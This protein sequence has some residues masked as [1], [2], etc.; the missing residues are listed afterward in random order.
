MLGAFAVLMVLFVALLLIQPNGSDP[1]ELDTDKGQS[2]ATGAGLEPATRGTSDTNP[3]P[4]A[5]RVKRPESLLELREKALERFEPWSSSF[6]ARLHELHPADLIEFLD[7]DE[8]LQHDDARNLVDKI[9]GL[10]GVPLGLL[11]ARED[12]GEASSADHEAFAA[13]DNPGVQWCLDLAES[14]TA[15]DAQR[16]LGQLADVTTIVDPAGTPRRQTAETLVEQAKQAGSSRLLDLLAHDD[17][18]TAAWAAEELYELRDT[19][20]LSDWSDIEALSDQQRHSVFDAIYSTLE[21]RQFGNCR[22]STLSVGSL[23]LSPGFQCS[24][25]VALD[26]VLYQSF[27]PAQLDAYYLLLNG[28]FQNRGGPG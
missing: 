12:M 14:E 11:A 16:R 1:D 10:C 13:L 21:C 18:L 7:D 23:C 6:L 20:F 9:Y 8:L 15:R 24:G 27:S 25:Q 5:D 2:E 3:K 26:G 17:A 4:E 28:I 19:T 22:V